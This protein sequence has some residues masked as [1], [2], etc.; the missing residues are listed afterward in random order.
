MKNIKNV[1]KKVAIVIGLLVIA[2]AILM[3][4]PNFKK[5]PNEGKINFIINNNN[6]TIKLKKDV[7]IDSNGVVYASKEDIANFICILLI[8]T[9]HIIH[10]KHSRKSKLKPQLNIFV[11]NFVDCLQ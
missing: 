5:D 2:V 11:F 4:S 1:W 3:I 8:T 7:F 10:F 9:K 6:V